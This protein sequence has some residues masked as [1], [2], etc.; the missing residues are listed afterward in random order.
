MTGLRHSVLLQEVPD[1]VEYP[2]VVAG[3]FA[4]DFLD[5]PEEVLT[6]TM[7]HH[8]H[9]FPVVTAEGRLK[10]A[11]L[12]V[13]N[14]QA[15]NAKTVARNSERVLTARLRDARF[16]WQADR[17]TTLESR[18]D[19]LGTLLFHK[20]AGTYLVK[21][22]RI[23][24]LARWLASEVFGAAEMT[25]LAGRAARLAK[26]D[27]T[28]DMVREFTEL[29]GTMGGIYAREE[30]LPESIWKAIYHQ[31]EPVGV[32]PAEGPTKQEIDGAALTWASLALAD[33]LDTLVSLVSAGE[34]PTG[35]RDP[36]GLR[37]QGN[38]IVK[39]LVDA[40]ALIG[41]D[42]PISITRL[43][44]EAWRVSAIDRAPDHWQ[45][46]QTFMLGRMGHLLKERG[47]RPDEAAAAMHAREADAPLHIA[48]RAEALREERDSVEFAAL[49]ELFKRVKNITKGVSMDSRGCRDDLLQ[50]PAE[51]A[52][53]GE[54]QRR[55]GTIED[56]VDRGRFRSALTEAAQMKPAVAAF[57]DSVRVL[58][59]DPDLRHTRLM[60]L[61]AVRDLIMRIADLSRIG[62]EEV[63]V[64]S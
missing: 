3:T 18:L 23:E 40:P 17:A 35:S 58:T 12:A 64:D 16:F 5:L 59:D 52:L 8:Q 36:F 13:T 4:P 11:F 63:P 49:A 42:A 29:Q 10:P 51:R 25:D 2:S 9:Y 1:L 7:I 54:L 34:Q 47:F 61:V 48:R 43:L 31:Y 15:D 41:F 38:G 6:V 32:S 56:H 62:E 24:A 39:I 14:T 53:Y 57:F 45:A 37:R 33:R 50:E 20:K 21:T 28:T 22:E 46:C 27:L 44:E 60:L 19:R 26:A 55:R 30:G